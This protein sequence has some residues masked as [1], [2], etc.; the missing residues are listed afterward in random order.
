[1]VIALGVLGC[2]G[3]TLTLRQTIEARTL[4]RKIA[5]QRKAIQKT[6]HPGTWRHFVASRAAQRDVRAIR[7]SD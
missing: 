6:W 5:I 1:M 7:G 2:W 3:W 4:T